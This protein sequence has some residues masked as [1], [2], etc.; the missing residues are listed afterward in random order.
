MGKKTTDFQNV[1]KKL[2]NSYSLT[3]IL[4]Q[5]SLNSLSYQALN[6]IP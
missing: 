4:F 3:G 1:A 5:E 2:K 6:L